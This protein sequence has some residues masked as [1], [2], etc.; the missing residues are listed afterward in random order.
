MCCVS[1]LPPTYEQTLSFRRDERIR[2]C[3][4]T[5]GTALAFH[6][7]FSSVVEFS[8]LCIFTFTPSAMASSPPTIRDIANA[9]ANFYMQYHRTV[10]GVNAPRRI[11]AARK[12]WLAILNRL[13]GGNLRHWPTEPDAIRQIKELLHWEQYDMWSAVDGTAR[14][15]ARQITSV[16]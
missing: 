6:S 13:R 15:S 14:V 11:E 4:A 9:W 16:S 2:G 3:H 10:G 12:E 7:S 5:N 1:S 8:A